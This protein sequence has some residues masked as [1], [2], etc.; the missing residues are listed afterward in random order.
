MLPNFV[1][2][3]S[4][5]FKQI[6]IINEC[7]EQENY[8]QNTNARMSRDKKYIDISVSRNMINKYL[9]ILSTEKKGPFILH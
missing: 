6:S 8:W 2:F 4:T 1:T 7:M 3:N 5:I 9:Y